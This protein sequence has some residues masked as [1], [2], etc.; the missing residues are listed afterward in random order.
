M[1]SLLYFVLSFQHTWIDYRVLLVFGD[2][3][4]APVVLPEVRRTNDTVL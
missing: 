3:E 1:K 4:D 2:R